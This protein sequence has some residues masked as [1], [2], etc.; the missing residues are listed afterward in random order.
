MLK[1]S[2]FSVHAIL[3]MTKAKA[4]PAANSRD[5]HKVRLPAMGVLMFAT[6]QA[7]LHAA[8][9]AATAIEKLHNIMHLSV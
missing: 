4:S 2:G 8:S 7:I 9:I 6:V 5:P 3:E 1:P